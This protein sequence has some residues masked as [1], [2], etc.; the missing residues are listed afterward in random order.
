MS[1]LP[2]PG[3]GPVPW[4][5]QQLWQAQGSNGLLTVYRAAYCPCTTPAPGTVPD[6]GQGDPS[7]PL[8]GG[9]A[10]VYPSAPFT[11]QAVV[12]DATSDTDLIATGLAEPGDIIVGTFPGGAH[13]ALWDLALLPW[14]IGVPDQGQLLV[15]GT[16][17]TDQTWYRMEDFHGA[18]SEV[19]GALT[20]YQLGQDF[21]WS[22]RTITWLP[23]GNA[24]AFGQTYSVRYAA[25]FEWI[26]RKEPQAIV[27]FGQDLGQRAVLRKRHEVLPGAGP[28]IEA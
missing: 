26:C 22:G 11:I 19:N 1:V 27:A 13:L 4:L 24:P 5:Y 3:T 12:T 23:G 10:F 28:I 25:R 6:P 9:T 16:G 21:A 20:T 15:R 7:C 8:C 14:N 18:W 2:P 17:S